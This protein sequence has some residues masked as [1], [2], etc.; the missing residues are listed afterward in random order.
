MKKDFTYRESIRHFFFLYALIPLAILMTVTL[1][2]I[3]V[4][5][6]ELVKSKTKENI[7]TL[8]KRVIA[9]QQS[10]ETFITDL[11]CSDELYEYLEHGSGLETV[12]SI[13]YNYNNRN[14][15][16]NIMHLM[17]ADGN[18][19]YSSKRLSKRSEQYLRIAVAPRLARADGDIL[20]E[21]NKL[22][23]EKLNPSSFSIAKAI[24]KDGRI[25][26]YCVLQ[27]STADLGVLLQLSDNEIVILTDSFGTLIYTNYN[28]AE[29]LG[30]K[31]EPE[32]NRK[33]TLSMNSSEFYYSVFQSDDQSLILYNLNL[34]RSNSSM[35]LVV[36]FVTL[37]FGI[38]F[39]ALLQL[40]ANRMVM[41][42]SKSLDNVV[43]AVRDIQVGEYDFSLITNENDEFHSLA[44]Q[45]Q[46]LVN[47][48]KDLLNRNEELAKLQRSSEVKLLEA[49][50]SPHFMLNVLET[51]RYSMIIDLDLAQQII[52]MLSNQLKYS[53]YNLKE[54]CC[55]EDELNYI[56]EYIKLHQIRFD[57]RIE[58]EILL[59]DELKKTIVPKLILQPIVENS[60]KYGF[61][62]QDDLKISITVSVADNDLVIAI[63][64]NGKGLKEEAFQSV[65]E[66]LEAEHWPDS[67][68][69]LYGIDKRLRLLYGE[70]YRIRIINQEGV[71]FVVKLKVPY[72]LEG[73]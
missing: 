49:Q 64:D 34:I 72:V 21:Y 45:Y 32:L 33:R 47:Q 27:L 46:N 70:A 18:I 39:F 71:S 38:F 41:Q 4:M 13:F 24:K 40:L 44:A 55:L 30:L 62:Y 57:N 31:F 37:F 60:I 61:R 50:F 2:A 54:N 11:T 28:K 42:S 53:L 20:F 58:Y 36:I 73:N 52:N 3:M 35:Y 19:V 1:I 29:K 63:L 12:T 22:Y 65:I 51:L 26:G 25:L 6:G 10:Y 8:S 43:T 59:P 69:G 9:M 5:P 15:V 67:H 16:S 68:I 48:I 66:L 23:Y 14:S 17:D 56:D 7:K